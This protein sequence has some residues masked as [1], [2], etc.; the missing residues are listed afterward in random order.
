MIACISVHSSVKSGMWAT[1]LL[2]YIQWAY[3]YLYILLLH[4]P[5]NDCIPAINSI[6]K[7]GVGG[8]FKKSG[9]QLYATFCMS[10]CLSSFLCS[11]DIPI[12]Y[13]YCEWI[14]LILHVL[15][16]SSFFYCNDILILTPT[17]FSFPKISQY[18]QRNLVNFLASGI[19]IYIMLINLKFL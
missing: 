6:H 18:P 17:T 8:V 12:S 19:S 15:F 2:L 7:R 13:F 4:Q 1:V 16:S 5:S 9:W 10:F 11:M 14:K 3:R